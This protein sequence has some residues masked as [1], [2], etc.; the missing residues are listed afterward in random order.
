MNYLISI[1]APTPRARAL[2]ASLPQR[3]GTCDSPPP[4][5]NAPCPCGAAQGS[6]TRLFINGFNVFDYLSPTFV[7]SVTPCV[8]LA[9]NTAHEIYFYFAATVSRR[10]SP[11][12]ARQPRPPLHS[13]RIV[14][15]LPR[16]GPS[17]HP[18]A[19]LPRAPMN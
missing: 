12:H 9:N 3:L 7:Q 5:P 18:P 10:K 15:C 13:S 17:T 11:A 14:T 6:H 8:T 19:R 16:H 2:A 1:T 4:L